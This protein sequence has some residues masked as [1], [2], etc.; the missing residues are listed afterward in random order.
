MYIEFELNELNR[1]V[2]LS[3]E[4]HLDILVYFSLSLI[5]EILTKNESL[6]TLLYVKNYGNERGKQIKQIVKRNSKE[7]FIYSKQR[8]WK[9]II[10]FTKRDFDASWHNMPTTL[11]GIITYYICKL[12]TVSLCFP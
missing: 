2:K 6:Y 8:A 7:N 11:K 12:M 10:N 9:V 5:P 4:Y 1:T 3:S